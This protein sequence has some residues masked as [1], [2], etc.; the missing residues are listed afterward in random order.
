M[1]KRSAAGVAA[2]ALTLSSAPAMAVPIQWTIPATPLASA[3]T[4]AGTFTYDA[5]TNA[6]SNLDLKIERSGVTTHFVRVESPS[7]W[8]SNRRLLARPAALDGKVAVL[9][10]TQQLT[11]AAGNSTL[12][13]VYEGICAES[14]QGI[15]VQVTSNVSSTVTTS[16]PPAPPAPVPTLS[17]WAMILLGV[18]L[19]G[20]AALTLQRRRQAA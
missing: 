10:F 16:P 19:A 6:Y 2:L 3:G 8:D 13:V 14:C 18:M 17:E 9:D 4:I 5:D 12:N 1:K 20:G 7:I 15:T 11:N